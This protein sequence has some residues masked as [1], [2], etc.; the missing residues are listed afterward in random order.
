MVLSLVVVFTL[1][2][3]FRQSDIL[4]SYME[5]GSG[6]LT[7]LQT[8]TVKD[9]DGNIYKTVTIGDHIWMAEN[10]KTTRYNDGSNIP[11]VTDNQQW[12][13]YE[14]AFSWYNN[15]EAKNKSE[16]GAL[17]NWYTINT[18]KLCPPAGMFPIKMN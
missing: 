10:L 4:T 2:L 5:T 16:Y 3:S 13:E 14:Q 1:F 7:D 8:Q 17:Y 11:L 15:N 18:N 9:I 6:V 12:Q